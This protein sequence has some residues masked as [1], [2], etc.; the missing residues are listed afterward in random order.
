[1]KN[2]NDDDDDWSGFAKHVYNIN[3]DRVLIIICI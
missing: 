2:I 3:D 1:M